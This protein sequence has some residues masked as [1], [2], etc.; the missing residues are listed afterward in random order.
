MERYTIQ[1]RIDF[2]EFY[3]QNSRSMTNTLRK[4]RA[5]YGRNFVI[6]KNT[7]QN[8]VDKFYSTGSVHDLPRSGHPR[9][10]RSIENIS[11][12][13]ESVTEN[14]RTSIRHRAQE[15]GLSRSSLHRILKLDLK[16]HAYKV[17]LTQ[18]IKIR[19][20]Y[21]RKTFAEWTLNQLEED[22]D[23]LKKIIFSDEAHFD[24]GGY[25]NKQNCRIWG[26]ENPRIFEEKP[27]HPQR[28]TV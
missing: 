13:S 16:L 25:V 28:V 18:Q 19:Y 27:M 10:A 14:P 7:V 3:I 22:E 2:I 11:V 23:F 21:Q 6:S 15:I 9:T 1:Q 4:I 26:S 5:K 12:V 24:L 17:Q 8:C 20:H